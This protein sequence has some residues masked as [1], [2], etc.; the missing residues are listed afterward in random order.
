MM[1][2]NIVLW[3][4]T[5]RSAVDIH[6]RFRGPYYHIFQGVKEA[7]CM[8]LGCYVHIAFLATCGYFISLRSDNEGRTFLRNVVELTPK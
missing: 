1:I 8:N 4:M 2:K 6:P 3:N 5:P 7:V